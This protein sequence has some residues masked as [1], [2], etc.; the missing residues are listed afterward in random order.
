MAESNGTRSSVPGSGQFELNINIPALRLPEALKALGRQAQLAVSYG[1]DVDRSHIFRELKGTYTPA[2]AFEELLKDTGFTFKYLGE[3]TIRIKASESSAG[4]VNEGAR[5]TRSDWRKRSAP[6]KSTSNREQS[7]R[8]TDAD[9]DLDKVVVTGSRLKDEK[10]ADSS[11]Q[12][13][14]DRDAL[15]QSGAATA[16]EFAQFVPENFNS[17]TPISSLFG[18]TFGP[19]QLGNNSFLGSGFNLWGLGPEATLTLVDGDRLV[20][21]GASGTFFD[22][23]LLPMNAVAGFVTL[24]GDTTAVYGSDAIAGVVKLTSFSDRAQMDWR[25]AFV[26]EPRLTEEEGSGTS[27]NGWAEL[28]R[29]ATG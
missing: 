13:V 29:V 10:A 7:V 15:E 5:V 2:H 27:R 17:V 14:Y 6:R 20:S 11:A 28:G 25:P 4:E 9:A 22:L 12:R 16:R 8:E 26:M 23:S 18:N 21:G 3:M 24:T 19:P 1:D